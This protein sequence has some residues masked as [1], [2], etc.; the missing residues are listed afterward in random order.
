[1][2]FVTKERSEKKKETRTLLEESSPP[3]VAPT[4]TTLGPPENWI[5]S[6]RRRRR[7]RREKGWATFAR[8]RYPACKHRYAGADPAAPPHDKHFGRTLFSFVI[9]SSALQ[10]TDGPSIVRVMGRLKSG[11]TA[12]K[13]AVGLKIAGHTFVVC[14]ALC[15]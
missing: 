14:P 12:G 10:S 1:M 13:V 5:Q 7:R 4:V 15:K 2:R 6:K 9:F 11:R 8:R 3:S